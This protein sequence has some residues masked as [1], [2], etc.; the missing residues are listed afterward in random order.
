MTRIALYTGGGVTFSPY[1]GEGRTESNY[2][3]LVSDNGK[4]MKNGVIYSE[5]RDVPIAEI[6][7]W[8]EVDAA[9]VEDEPTDEDYA[10]AGKILMGKE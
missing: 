4:V 8:I 1:S 9:S 3:R 5:C 2:V 10:E 7:N 6:N